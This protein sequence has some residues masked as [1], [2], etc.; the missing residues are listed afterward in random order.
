MSKSIVKT[1]TKPSKPYPDFPL[2]PHATRRWAKKIRGK[3]HYFGPWE[4]SDGA[5]QKYID[6]RDDLH[7]GRAPRP[8][9]DG[10]TLRDLLNRFLTAKQ[11]KVEAGEMKDRTFGD[12]YAAGARLV[13]AFGPHRLVDDL[14]AEDFG[15]FRAELAKIRGP[16]AL[17]NEIQRVR[18]IFK[19]GYDAGLIDRPIRFG[20]EFVKPSAKAVR[21]ARQA[22]GER[23]FTPD[24][25]LTLLDA[26]SIQMKAMILLGVNCGYG[27]TDVSDL[28]MSAV[29]LDGAVIDFPRPKTAVPRRASLWPETVVAL[30]EAIAARPNAKAPEDEGLVFITKYGNRWVKTRSKQ[31]ALDDD[32]PVFITK[33]G[34]GSVKTNGNNTVIDAVCKQ[35]GKLAR[36]GFHTLRHTFR[37]IADETR[38]LPA[39]DR[40]MGHEDST[41]MATRY[42][43]RIDDDRLRAVTDHVREWLF[44]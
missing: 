3:L 17:G 18:T 41:S 40:I 6:Q 32:G 38:D 33:D 5:L 8:T 14:R 16:V 27:N 30:R 11:R 15:R 37:T 25:I 12:Y 28:P 44:G 35:F 20:P 24:Q 19:Y 34:N 1:P 13:D 7:A 39:V 9:L 36:T 4:D 10:L 2:F 26:A 21:Q 22:K 31:E 23:M 42:R 43:E 29:D